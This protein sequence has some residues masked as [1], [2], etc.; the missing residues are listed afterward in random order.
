[1]KNK[2]IV[3]FTSE[4]LKKVLF[5]LIWKNKRGGKNS[6][7]DDHNFSNGLIRKYH[8]GLYG[9]DGFAAAAV[10]LGSAG[11]ADGSNGYG[12]EGNVRSFLFSEWKGEKN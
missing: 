7:N 12:G 6:C 10:G 3:I 2:S 9:F 8:F 11:G 4:I 1:M 5:L